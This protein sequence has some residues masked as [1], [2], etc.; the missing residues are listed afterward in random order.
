MENWS[1]EKAYKIQI[2]NTISFLLGLAKKNSMIYSLNIKLF[3]NY[4]M[5]VIMYFKIT[6]IVVFCRQ[7]R[8]EGNH[9]IRQRMV[10]TQVPTLARRSNSSNSKRSSSS[11]SLGVVLLA[12][13]VGRQVATLLALVAVWWEWVLVAAAV[14]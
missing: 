5:N 7:L 4:Q 13:M 3:F 12:T 8:Q 14:F 10:Q 11:S 9:L 2:L 1:K 6:I